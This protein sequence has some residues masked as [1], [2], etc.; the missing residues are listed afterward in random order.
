ML[1]C[2]GFDTNFVSTG[3][4]RGAADDAL[5]LM[6]VYTLPEVGMVAVVQTVL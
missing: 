6:A 4:S 3:C 2:A 1:D 5:A